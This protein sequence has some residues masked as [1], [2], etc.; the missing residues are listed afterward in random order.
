MRLVKRNRDGS[1]ATQAARREV[2]SQVAHDLKDM[3][4]R[5]L[6][7]TG[8]KPKHV[9]ALVKRW[10]ATGIAVG[11]MKNRMSHIRWWAEKVGKQSCVPR[12]NDELGIGRRRYVTNI[13]KALVLAQGDLEKI[14]DERVRCSVE[15]QQS[16]GLRREECL[17]FQ[18]IYALDGLTVDEVQQIHLKPTWCKGGRERVV[19]ITDEHQR[20]VLARAAAFCGSGSMIPK[21]FKYVDQLRR[22]I[23]E[24]EKAGM[25]KLH[26]LRHAY[27]QRRY[28]QLT[29]WPAPAAGGPVLAQL[30]EQQRVVDRAARLQVSAELGH[31]R[32]EITAVYLG[33]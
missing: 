29:G 20:A 11:T 24:V 6:P 31:N 27:A 15:L 8:L 16:F 17:K 28:H 22:Y 21:E 25:S 32:E 4:F 9:A 10:Q 7:A 30:T 2:L 5:T 1:Y 14:T 3:G 12:T 26:G 13:S 18:A 23:S 19:P 33:R